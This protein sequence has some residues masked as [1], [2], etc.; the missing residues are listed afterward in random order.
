[1]FVYVFYRNE[2]KHYVA[3]HRNVAIGTTVDTCPASFHFSLSYYY[4]Y[5]ATVNSG[6]EYYQTP[7]SQRYI[8]SG[9][10]VVYGVLALGRSLEYY[11]IS[12][13]CLSVF[14]AE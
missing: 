9:I 12:Q 13:F 7:E 14:Y 10:S 11:V 2:E 1:M 5:P 3:R 8:G 6:E 4:H